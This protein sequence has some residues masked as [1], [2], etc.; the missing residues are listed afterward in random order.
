MIWFD[1]DWFE[2][3]LHFDALALH[4]DLADPDVVGVEESLEV[5]LPVGGRVVTHVDLVLGPKGT[6]SRSEWSLFVI[7]ESLSEE[8][9]ENW[10]ST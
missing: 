7:N 4:P 5:R 1:F 9:K 6:E 10:R 2:K 3:N 8:T